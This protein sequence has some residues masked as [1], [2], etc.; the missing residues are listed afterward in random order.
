MQDARR[1]DSEPALGLCVHEVQQGGQEYESTG[2]AK[3]DG[4]HK[5]LTIL[6]A[7][8]RKHQPWRASG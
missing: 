7:L 5:L 2:H 4:M 6:N 3:P 1:V 8:L